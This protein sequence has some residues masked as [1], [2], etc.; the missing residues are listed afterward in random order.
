MTASRGSGGVSLLDLDAQAR[1][2]IEGHGFDEYRCC[3]VVAELERARGVDTIDVD[4]DR[5]EMEPGGDGGDGGRVADRE[6]M[7]FDGVWFRLEHPERDPIDR[8]DRPSG[9]L[10]LALDLPARLKQYGVQRKVTRRSR[11]R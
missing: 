5:A 8:V 11:R 7:S 1:A 9:D 3:A 10:E 2:A 4:R 6:V